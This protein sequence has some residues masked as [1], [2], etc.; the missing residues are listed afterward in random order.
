MELEF[1][2][3]IMPIIII[4]LLIFVFISQGFILK[5]IKI[6]MK[7]KQVPKPPECS[8]KINSLNIS[9]LLYSIYWI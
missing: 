7:V 6:N 3:M 2:Q 4:L 8:W 5:K 9:S 1:Y